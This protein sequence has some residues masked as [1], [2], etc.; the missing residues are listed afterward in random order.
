MAARSKSPVEDL[1]DNRQ[2][3]RPVDQTLDDAL[4]A[5]IDAT[6]AAEKTALTTILR[7]E[8]GSHY[9]DCQR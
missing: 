1:P 8:L 6:E 7:Y 3:D 5:T 9:L 2:Y 4:L